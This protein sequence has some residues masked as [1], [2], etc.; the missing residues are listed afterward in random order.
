MT[1]TITNIQAY[2]IALDTLKT[3]EDKWKTYIKEEDR[4]MSAFDE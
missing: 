3:F 4:R 2:K 1:K